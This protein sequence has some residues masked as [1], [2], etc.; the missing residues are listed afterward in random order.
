[1]QLVVEC[2]KC[3]FQMTEVCLLSWCNRKHDERASQRYRFESH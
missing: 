1:M 2:L 3:L